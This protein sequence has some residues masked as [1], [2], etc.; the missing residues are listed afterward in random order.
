LTQTEQSAA[1]TTNA[2]TRTTRPTSPQVSTTTTDVDPVVAE[3]VSTIPL[4]LIF[5]HITGDMRVSLL[6][7]SHWRPTP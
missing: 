3:C 7:Y 2:A 1:T 4:F 5:N 6:A